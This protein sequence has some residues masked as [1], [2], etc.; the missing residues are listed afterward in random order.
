MS[1]RPF[2]SRR[3]R[4]YRRLWL[5]A[6]FPG[7]TLSKRQHRIAA[8]HAFAEIWFSNWYLW[9]LLTVLSGACLALMIAFF[10]FMGFLGLSGNGSMLAPCLLGLVLLV[11]LPVLG[12]AVVDVLLLLF[13]RLWIGHSVR[14][15]IRRGGIDIC[16]GCGYLLTGVADD[17]PCP[18]CGARNVPVGAAT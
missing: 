13:V 9:H 14:T 3:W 7:A 1:K 10:I 16:V 11:I 4:W 17:Q 8:E 15:A 2:M 5:R 6:V 18:E 12:A